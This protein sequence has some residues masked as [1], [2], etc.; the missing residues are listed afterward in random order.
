MIDPLGKVLREAEK[1]I[2][3]VNAYIIPEQD[4]IDAIQRISQR[5]VSVRILTNSLSS[6]DVPAVNS[7]Y[8]PWRKPIVASGAELYELRSDA[9][10]QSGICD[11]PPTR[12]GFVGLHSKAMVVDREWS[13]IGS[14]NFDPRSAALNS[15][16]GVIVRSPGLGEAL[17]RLIERDMRPANSWQVTLDQEG[18]LQWT[19]DTKTVHRQPARNAWQ[20]VEEFFFRGIPKEYY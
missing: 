1:G 11:T 9:G 16:M 10:I 12:A 6:H 2:H 17:A 5:G 19:N 8:A 7:H 4:F 20:R 18:R 3:I 15:E 13:Y 14:M